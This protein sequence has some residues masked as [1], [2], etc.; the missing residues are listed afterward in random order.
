M[1]DLKGQDHYLE[2]SRLTATYN[3]QE[4][5]SNHVLYEFRGVPII[6]SATILAPI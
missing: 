1:V 2:I 4:K 3:P 6:E 5:Y